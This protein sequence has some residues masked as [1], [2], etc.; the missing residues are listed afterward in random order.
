LILVSMVELLQ[1]MPDPSQR[2]D[3]KIAKII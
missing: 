2:I 1:N 3:M